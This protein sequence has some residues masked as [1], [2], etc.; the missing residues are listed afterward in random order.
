MV[1]KRAAY[2]CL[3][4]AALAGAAGAPRAEHIKANKLSSPIQFGLTA[5]VVREN[6]R[7]LNQW[8]HYLSEKVGHPVEFVRRK[9]YRE[10]MNLLDT[11][12][13]DFAWI[14]GFPF[15]K[16]REPEFIRLMSVPVYAGKPL[17]HSFIIVHRDSPYQSIEDLEGKVFAFSDPES[18]SGFL[19]PQFLLASKGKTPEGFFRQTFFTYNHAETIEAVAEQ[20]ANGGAV[21]SYIWE[22]LADNHPELTEKTRIIKTSPA[23]G[24]PPLVMRVGM[25]PWMAQRM[26]EVLLNMSNDPEGRKFLSGL[27]LDSFGAASPELFDSI[28][29]MVAE[30]RKA[31][32]WAAAAESRESKLARGK[33]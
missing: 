17:Y 16:K 23:F 5:V 22:Y 1:W 15:V 12:Q 25:E 10:V 30:T 26:K 8:A 18:N 27:K 4:L 14:C 32:P 11:G 19:F 9:S 13:L 20:V 24:F 21:D 6:L 7:F 2:L 3:V 33:E 28:R 29:E 31:L